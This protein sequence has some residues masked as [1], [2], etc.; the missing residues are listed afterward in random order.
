MIILKTNNIFIE[1]KIVWVNVVKKNFPFPL[2]NGSN[3][4]FHLTIKHLSEKFKEDEFICLGKN[5][6]NM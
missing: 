5:K 1:E 2:H 3:C 4:D 6:K